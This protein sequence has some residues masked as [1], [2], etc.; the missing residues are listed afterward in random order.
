V[1]VIVFIAYL[2]ASIFISLFSF[3]ATAIL[4]CFIID[5]ELSTQNGRSNQHTPQSL[6]PFLAKN[7]QMM[8]KQS[9][10]LSM[11]SDLTKANQ[12]AN[13]Q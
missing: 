5:S 7:E 13:T 12:V 1:I 11:V 4:H 10:I 9:G 3:S 6:Q 2:I 8:M